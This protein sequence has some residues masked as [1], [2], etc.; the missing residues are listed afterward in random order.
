MLSSLLM[1]APGAVGFWGNDFS[2]SSIYDSVLSLIHFS[3][4]TRTNVIVVASSCCD[5]CRQ[6]LRLRGATAGG[7]RP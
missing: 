6:G 1:L 3:I 7:L 4:Q 5:A 2:A